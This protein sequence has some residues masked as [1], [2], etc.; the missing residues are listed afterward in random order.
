[1]GSRAVRAGEDRLAKVAVVVE[2]ATTMV[3]GLASLAQTPVPALSA[4]A[5]TMSRP[6]NVCTTHQR[7]LRMLLEGAEEF[8]RK[9]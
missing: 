1:M 8:L 4:K 7:T 6:G 3:P 5:W 2:V 9:R